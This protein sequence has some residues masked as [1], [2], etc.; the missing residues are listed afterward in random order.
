MA[1]GSPAAKAKDR[2][3]LKLNQPPLSSCRINIPYRY[4]RWDATGPLAIQTGL[5]RA[6]LG[7]RR[8]WT[9]V[10]FGILGYSVVRVLFPNRIKQRKKD[11]TES[12]KVQAQEDTSP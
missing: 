8:T 10:S 2:K 6:G 5:R 4:Q 1:A 11:W 9:L 3:Y 7:V 12:E